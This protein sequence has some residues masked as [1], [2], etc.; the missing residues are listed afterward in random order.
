[1]DH[2]AELAAGRMCADE[3]FA[4]EHDTHADT[5][6]EQDGDEVVTITVGTAPAQRNGHHVAVVLDDDRNAERLFEDICERNIAVRRYWRPKHGTRMGI[7]SA[8]DSEGN[9][10][11]ASPNRGFVF[12]ALPH[13]RDTFLD[14]GFPRQGQGV[15]P[16]GILGQNA[17]GIVGD[18]RGQEVER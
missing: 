9:T 6:R 5:V 11:H 14:Q 1:M 7:G 18:R 13:D 8:L 17:P 10:Q 15:Q 3:Q 2:V 4:V 12:E 16:A